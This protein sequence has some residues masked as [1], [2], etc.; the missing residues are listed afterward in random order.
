MPHLLLVSKPSEAS[1]YLTVK[2]GLNV[3]QEKLSSWKYNAKGSRMFH[4]HH[5]NNYEWA[6]FHF[7]VY[8]DIIDYGKRLCCCLSPC[9]HKI[10]T[11]L[12]DNFF[13]IKNPLNTSLGQIKIKS[14]S[15]HPQTGRALCFIKILH[16]G[17]CLT[18]KLFSTFLW[19]LNSCCRYRDKLWS[20]D[21]LGLYADFT[22]Y[23]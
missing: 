12:I 5:F 7:E 20:D 15:W 14:R 23:Q 17:I 2:V 8:R 21:L 13:F 4:R 19:F 11:L 9:L 3:W 18:C 1:S 10:N 6:I 16:C 22:D